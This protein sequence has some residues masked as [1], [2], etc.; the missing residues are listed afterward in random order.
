MSIVYVNKQWNHNCVSSREVVSSSEIWTVENSVLTADLSL[1]KAII[2]S[3][4]CSTSV[5]ALVM[6]NVVEVFETLCIN[7][8]YLVF[9]FPFFTTGTV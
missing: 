8:W 7:M 3:D 1:I 4:F 6:M 9:S 5:W 2:I